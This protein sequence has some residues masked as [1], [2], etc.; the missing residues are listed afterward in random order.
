MLQLIFWERKLYFQPGQ[1]PLDGRLQRRNQFRV[2][3]CVR[4]GDYFGGLLVMVEMRIRMQQL[5]HVTCQR[6]ALCFKLRYLA[7][8][9]V[10]CFAR[11]KRC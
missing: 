6:K 4:A 2:Y 3:Y 7:D 8:I 5:F 11:Q 10:Y 1:P 9:L